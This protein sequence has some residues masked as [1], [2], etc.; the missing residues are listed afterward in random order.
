MLQRLTEIHDRIVNLK[1]RSHKRYLYDEVNWSL[2]ALC[3]YGARGTGKTT[4]MIQHY[5]EQYAS[6]EKA[7]YITAD[8][9]HVLSHGLYEV[10]DT[11]FKSG[12]QALYIDEIHKYPDWSVELKNILD[13][14]SDKQI[15]ISGSSTLDLRKSKGDLSRRIVYYELM[16]LSFREFLHLEKQIHLPAVTLKS[17]LKN[18]VKLASDIKNKCSILKEFSEYLTYGYY[19]F[20][21]EGKKEYIERLQNVIEKVIFEDIVFSFNLSQPKIPVLKKLLWIIA[22]SEPFVPNMERI[23]KDL[24]ISREYVYHYI[25]YLE[26]AGLI[27]NLRKAGQGFNP[28]RKP[29]KIFLQNTG[30]IQ[31]L[32]EKSIEQN[33]GSARECFIV[34]QLSCKH[35]VTIPSQGDF[36][37]DDQYILEAG[38]RNKDKK[39]IESLA[40]AWLVLDDIE[41]GYQQTIPLYLLGMLY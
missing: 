14:Y 9:V 8:H 15:I 12:G 2:N 22:N 6:V 34:N 37:V 40:N 20:F 41:I 32:S 5:Q 38:G 19:P 35:Q 27:I 11:Y 26:K 7:L 30:L 28:M 31:A 39:Q 21:L 16:G 18:H 25:E 36:L 24:G 4:L 17:L 29:A 13:V 3:F 1:I 33:K 10:A 23:S